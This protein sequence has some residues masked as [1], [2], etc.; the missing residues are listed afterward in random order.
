MKPRAQE[1]PTTA[2]FK[3]NDS[4]KTDGKVSTG[5]AKTAASKNNATADA[6]VSQGKKKQ[7][8]ATSAAG[9]KI[10][11]KTAH[12]LIE[13][14]RRSKMNEEFAVLKGMIPACTGEMHKL[15]ILQA[16][17]D[18]VR[19]LED[20]VGKLKAQHGEGRRDRGRETAL[21]ALPSIRDFHP[22]FHADPLGDV[23]MSDSDTASP[24]FTGQP[25]HAHA[26]I[27]PGLQPDDA[28]H[29]QQPCSFASTER[30]H[31]SFSASA[32]ASPAFGP[33]RCGIYAPSSASGSTLTSPALNPQS[34]LDHEATAALLMLNNDRRGTHAA[35][36]ARGLSV[37]DLLST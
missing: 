7:P 24:P 6:G 9:R 18:Y 1:E 25:D 33:Q 5:T 28:R 21:N 23:D 37:R 4:G 17:I 15:A 35:L 36:N 22:P 10:A 14:R 12:S 20:C 3:A 32:G 13:R 26:S 2:A 31:Y 27:S 30:R 34:D 29:R 8:S 11:R 16:A 19:Y